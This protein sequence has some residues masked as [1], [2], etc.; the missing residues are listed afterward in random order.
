MK[1]ELFLLVSTRETFMQCAYTIGSKEHCMK[2][3]MAHGLRA[4]TKIIPF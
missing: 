3:Q 1:T 4:H 2:Y